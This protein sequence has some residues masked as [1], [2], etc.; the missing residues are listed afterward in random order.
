[1]LVGFIRLRQASGPDLGGTDASA[2]GAENHSLFFFSIKSLSISHRA[3]APTEPIYKHAIG[4][5]C[6]TGPMGHQKRGEG[7]VAILAV[8]KAT[9]TKATAMPPSHPS[10]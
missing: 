5:G 8:A 3:T 2:D 1:V 6:N 9:P 4:T 7:M 10:A